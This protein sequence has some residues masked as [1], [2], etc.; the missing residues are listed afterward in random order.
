MGIKPWAHNPEAIATTDGHIVVFT[1]GNGIPIHGP[2][3]DCNNQTQRREGSDKL[4]SPVKAYQESKTSTTPPAPSGSSDV[5]FTLH[6]ASVSNG[7]FA[8][9]SNWKFLN[10]T[11]QDFPNQFK[12]QGNWNP[13]PVQLPDGRVRVMAHTGWSGMA[14]AA[15]GWSGEVILEASSWRGPYR[16][17]SSRDIT[18]CTYCEEDPYMWQHHRN[19][20]HVLYHRMFDN[21]TNVKSTDAEGLWSGAHSYSADGVH[22]S[23]LYRCYNT[24]VYLEG[25]GS[26]SFASRERPKLLLNASGYPTHLSNAVQP[27]QT[28]GPDAGVTHTLIVPLRL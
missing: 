3:V 17:I 2:E 27:F 9:K 11:I 8:E 24:T 18:T 1:L 28:A 10:A 25:G 5:N 19:N 15:V 16:V 21:G 13:A 12:F 4:E 7:A 20:W 14:N 6:Y 26:Q 22:W 23:P